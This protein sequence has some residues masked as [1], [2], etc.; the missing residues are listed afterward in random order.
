[1]LKVTRRKMSFHCS[2]VGAI[3]EHS[4]IQFYID[5]LCTV[6]CSLQMRHAIRV[7]GII[8]GS[9]QCCSTITE[10]PWLQIDLVHDQSYITRPNSPYVQ[11]C[12]V[13]Y[14]SNNRMDITNAM[15]ATTIKA[16]FTTTENADLSTFIT[17]MN[18]GHDC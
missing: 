17:H 12:V 10:A 5:L 14:I 1:V 4:D 7:A 2:E 15:S 9:I 16:P 8:M 3:Q 11:I 18:P 6:Q 13:L